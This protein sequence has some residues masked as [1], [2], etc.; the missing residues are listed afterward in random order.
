MK[1]PPTAARRKRERPMPTLRGGLRARTCCS[2]RPSSCAQQAPRTRVS[3]FNLL[4]SL[5]L[6][7]LATPLLVVLLAPSFGSSFVV[8][9]PSNK[10]RPLPRWRG[11][12]SSS[13]SSE[14]HNQH[15]IQHRLPRLPATGGGSRG[16][17]NSK[18]LGF[19]ESKTRRHSL[20]D[21]IL[22]GVAAALE[23]PAAEVR[24]ASRAGSSPRQQGWT[25]QR[26]ACKDPRE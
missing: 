17:S 16:I 19:R 20:Q 7:L 26:H 21:E 1:P 3:L 6:S 24:P 8:V 14:P 18:V 23:P 15:R 11:G 25:Y 12:S 22:E 4:L 5:S 13:A 2:D 10:A 9:A